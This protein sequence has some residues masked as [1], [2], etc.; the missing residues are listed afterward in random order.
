M[1]KRYLFFE[2]I[3]RFTYICEGDNSKLYDFLKIIL[4]SVN[5]FPAQIHYP[6][7]PSFPCQ[8]V[9]QADCNP[10]TGL[11]GLYNVFFRCLS[12]FRDFV[13]TLFVV[14]E[15]LFVIRYIRLNPVSVKF[16]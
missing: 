13:K 10:E 9:I 3:F 12:I 11:T 2:T 14:L 15:N 4:P 8:V 1:V 5:S 6:E 7:E 16:T